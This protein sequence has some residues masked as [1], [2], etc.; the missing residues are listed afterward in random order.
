MDTRKKQFTIERLISSVDVPDWRKSKHSFFISQLRY[1]CSNIDDYMNSSLK[2]A[3]SISL[4]LQEIN[5]SNAPHTLITSGI[6]SLQKHTA[7]LKG[8]EMQNP[9][10]VKQG[11]QA[12]LQ[13][14]KAA[15][16][17]GSSFYDALRLCTGQIVLPPSPSGTSLF[18]V[19]APR[20]ISP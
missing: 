12:W 5:G 16:V 3:K 15:P 20:F 14:R 4:F 11:T 1:E 10:H 18:F 17:T 7:R 19:V 9:L 13:L 2:N 8:R 6:L